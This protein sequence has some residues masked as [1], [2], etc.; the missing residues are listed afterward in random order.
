MS[1]PSELQRFAFL[2]GR[3][4]CQ[5]ELKLPAE[6]SQRFDALWEGRWALDGHAIVDEY[7][8]FGANGETLVLGVNIRAYDVAKKQWNIKWLDALLG[9]WTD[10]GSQELGGVHFEGASVSYQFREPMVGH[11]FTR[12]TYTDISDQHFTWRGESSEDGKEWTE[13]MVVECEREA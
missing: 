5:A 11:T 10:L 6:E 7:R 1:A 12:A 8:M 3:Y 9:R 2:V 4:R 13:F